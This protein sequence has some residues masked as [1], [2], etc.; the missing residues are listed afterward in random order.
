MGERDWWEQTWTADEEMVT[1]TVHLPGACHAEV[2]LYSPEFEASTDP[3]RYD[4]ARALA[5]SPDMARV[6]L[7]V[8]WSGREGRDNDVAC[9]VCGEW[10]AFGKHRPD[11]AL[12]AALR[13]AGVR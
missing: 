9:P 8:E 10:E 2:R 4:L 6:L 7:A 3:I 13:K 1:P 5:A 12:D 11:C